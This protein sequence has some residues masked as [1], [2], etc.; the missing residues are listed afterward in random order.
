M[1]KESIEQFVLEYT[2][3]VDLLDCVNYAIQNGFEEP[4]DY[5]GYGCNIGFI[6][7]E[8]SS[9][10][11]EAGLKEWYLNHHNKYVKKKMDENDSLEFSFP[12]MFNFVSSQDLN[13]Q[14]HENGADV[15]VDNSNGTYL[16]KIKNGGD[17]EHDLVI[18][19]LH[20]KMPW[21]GDYSPIFE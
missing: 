19:S 9:V 2:K 17:N 11:D 21:G 13:I 1:T 7:A 15:E 10:K 16:L 20:F 18:D 12:P 6:K 4:E 14:L 3:G 8:D 5:N